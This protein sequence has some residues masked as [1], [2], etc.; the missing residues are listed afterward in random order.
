MA[1]RRIAIVAGGFSS[2]FPVSMKSAEGIKTFLEDTPYDTYIV[3]ITRD[4]WEV[5][6]PDG[7]TSEIDK[8]DFSFVE[9]S[10]I[11]QFDFAYITI[12]G[13]PGENGALQGYFDMIGLPYSCC[14][15]FAAALT[16]NKYSCN[17]YLSNFG[18]KI[19]PAVI[20]RPGDNYSVSDIVK[21]V[22]LPCFV[23]PNE[24]GSSFA[25]TKV[26]EVSELAKAIED[27]FGEGGNVI[28]E[29]FMQGTEVTCGC[30]KTDE[31]SVV[32][33]ITEVVSKNEF[34]DYEAKYTAS[35]VEEI[36]PARISDDIAEEISATTSMI[37][38]IIGAKGIIRVDYIIVQGVPY[39]LEVNTT[40]GMTV[41]SF[42]PQQIRASKL[43]PG[44]VLSEIIEDIMQTK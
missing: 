15:V 39:L 6:L 25:T 22:S 4:L 3:K 12:H 26:K 17:Q 14:G 20:I 5:I 7:T 16:A 27:A 21:Q 2:E 43:E 32:F 18:V 37:Y 41:T 36:T 34:F 30:Y 44:K 42:I 13:V 24:G 31:K 8:N 28:V 11:K 33:P 23:K 40:P 29:R 9:G 38:D 10:K 1:T 35:K 19:S